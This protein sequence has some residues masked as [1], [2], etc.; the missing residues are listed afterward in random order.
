MSDSTKQSSTNINFEAS[1]KK[2]EAIVREFERGELD[3]EVGL[4]RFKEALKLAETCKK[5]L[6]EVETKVVKIK[7]QFADFYQK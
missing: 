5:R 1:F 7:E 6:D 3:L 4:E 2:L